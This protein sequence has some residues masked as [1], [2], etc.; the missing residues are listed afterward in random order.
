MALG[1]VLRFWDIAK[2]SIWHDEGFSLMLAPMSPG[3]IIARTGRDVH[4]PL[5]YLV[6][7]YWMLVFGRSET[8]VRGLS[9]V[10]LIAAIPLAHLLIRRLWSEPAGRL[11][12]LF[13]ACGPFLIRYSQETRMYGMVAFLL[14]AGTYLLVRALEASSWKW[15]AAYTLVMSA[16]MYTH[17]YTVFMFIVHGLYLLAQ[18]WR[19]TGHG[20][21]NGRWW[22]SVAASILLF[23][24]WLPTAYGQFTRVQASFWIPPVN[25]GTVPSTMYQFLLYGPVNAPSP[26]GKIGLGLAFVA[27]VVGLV[28]AWLRLRQ[29]RLSLW[30]L[31]CYFLVGPVLVFVLSFR[32]PI[33]VD[34]YF[35]F[36]AIGFACLLA[37]LVVSL[38]RRWLQVVA[39]LGIVVLA[40]IGIQNVHATS[41]HQ[42]RAIGAYV[43]SHYRP[44][45]EILSGEIYTFFDFSYYNHTGAIVHLWSTN[46]VN[47]YN[48]SSLIYDRASQIV[49]EQLSTIH[50]RSGNLWVVGEPGYQKYYDPKVIPKAWV[51]TGPKIIAGNSAVQEYRVGHS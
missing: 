19:G 1:T 13:V 15:W 41:N 22:A 50:P 21:R 32:R 6:L 10:F 51:P 24:P 36:A 49:V 23:A 37:V 27:F 42:M 11:A 20:L 31:G 4:P 8:A 16:A 35:V 44:G 45:D 48:E 28:V 17:Y 26:T 7:H 43:T 38:P 25:I 12:A 18:S 34:R 29:H 14:L 9:A 33:Y 2:S 3:Q 46:G 30:L 47:G 40:G 5:Y 39:T